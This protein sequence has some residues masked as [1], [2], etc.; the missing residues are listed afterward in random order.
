MYFRCIL[1]FKKILFKPRKALPASTVRGAEENLV[2]SGTEKTR[3]PHTRFSNDEIHRMRTET[4][5]D[6]RQ[7]GKL[8][9][10]QAHTDNKTE[11]E[12]ERE[13]ERDK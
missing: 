1:G 11:T 10:S 3:E 7:L 13:R 4:S 5:E 9:L 8:M 6:W 12:R 2:A